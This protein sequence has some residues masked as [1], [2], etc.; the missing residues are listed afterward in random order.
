MAS[1][2]QFLDPIGAGATLAFLKLLE[3]RTETDPVS[4]LSIQEHTLKIIPNTFI[5]NAWYRILNKDSRDDM[6]HLFAVIVRFI[7]LFMN[8]KK[9]K[10]I[11]ISHDD[12]ISGMS[13]LGG[14][15]SDVSTESKKDDDDC[16]EELKTIAQ[17]MIDGIHVL[18]KTYEFG[19]PVFTL[20]Y[21]V[22]LLRLSMDDNYNSDKLLPPHLVGLSSDTLFDI[23]KIKRLWTNGNIKTLCNF[24]GECFKAK[25]NND[26][27]ILES[28]IARLQK[29][30]SL[31]N[32]EFQK[33]IIQT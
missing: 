14:F 22:V 8:T 27:V 21:F 13:L 25:R 28:N 30:L 12:V 5:Q 32:A 31:Q 17:Y 16:H 18:E 7:E 29:F 23:S 4:K 33:M 10:I 26:D 2:M 1:K 19:N 6:C 20:Q 15:S 11:P 3:P 9:P 24:L